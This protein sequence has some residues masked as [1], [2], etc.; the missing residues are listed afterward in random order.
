[1]RC[2]WVQNKRFD[3]CFISFLTFLLCDVS[4]DVCWVRDKF[5]IKSPV[6]MYA[7]KPLFFFMVGSL[8]C[9][10]V[11][12]PLW[13]VPRLWLLLWLLLLLLVLPFAFATGI[14]RCGNLFSSFCTDLCALC[15]DTTC[16]GL[17]TI[18]GMRDGRLVLF[19]WCNCGDD[20]CGDADVLLYDLDCD[21]VVSQS[22]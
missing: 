20:K 13:L 19:V 11:V 4:P 5:K 7:S 3:F 12:V 8:V 9:D 14:C 1:M 2:T 17:R 16:T 15:F 22:E 18:V 21:D 6:I 10:V